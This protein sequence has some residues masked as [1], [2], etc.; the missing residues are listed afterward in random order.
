MT[1]QTQ[2]LADFTEIVRGEAGI[3]AAVLVGSLVTGVVDE[4]SDLDLVLIVDEAALTRVR[5]NWRRLV[6]RRV[7]YSSDSRASSAGPRVQVLTADLVILDMTF[8]T[9][10]CPI[11]IH[12]PYRVL[13]DDEVVAGLLPRPGSR[14]SNLDPTQE[15]VDPA[16]ALLEVVRLYMRGKIGCALA[17]LDCI[18]TQAPTTAPIQHNVEAGTQRPE[19]PKPSMRAA[20]FRTRHRITRRGRRTM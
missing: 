4:L 15:Q 17:R 10:R 3:R 5:R 13:F 12:P 18:A 14:P 11:P 9:V 16:F 6:P 19:E 8:C 7:L 20:P 1:S 2:L